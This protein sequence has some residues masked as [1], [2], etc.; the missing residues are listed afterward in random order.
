MT[1]FSIGH[2]NIWGLTSKVD[3]IRFLLFEHKFKVFCVPETFLG[4]R[5]SDVYC[6]LTNYKIVC[7]DRGHSNGGGL[8]CCSHSTVIEVVK[9]CTYNRYPSC[10]QLPT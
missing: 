8:H 6:T 7:R 2:L 3:E 5:M 4:E 10:I 9:F 1:G